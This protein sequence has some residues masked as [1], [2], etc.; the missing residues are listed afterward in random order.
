MD[1]E[2]AT[3]D[4]YVC[5]YRTGSN[6]TFYVLGGA[7]EVSAATRCVPA[8]H[9]TLSDVQWMPPCPLVAPYPPHAHTGWGCDVQNELIL[10][11][12]VDGMFDAIQSLL[13]YG[14]IQM[15]TCSIWS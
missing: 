13:K 14:V 10:A 1:C 9:A 8:T 15:I 2:V 7:E 11:A 12:V 6:I 3:L 5:V 4:P